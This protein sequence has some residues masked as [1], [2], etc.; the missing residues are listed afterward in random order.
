VPANIGESRQAL[1]FTGDSA[2][3]IASGVAIELPEESELHFHA[4]AGAPTVV[5]AVIPLA[6]VVNVHRIV[7]VR[8]RVGDSPA[9]FAENR[10]CTRVV[11][12]G[13]G[14]LDVAKVGQRRTDLMTRAVSVLVYR[15]RVRG[16]SLTS[17]PRIQTSDFV[18]GIGA[19]A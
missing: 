11:R 3:R 6:R 16:A 1:R 13:R 4:A 14:V 5:R 10:R 15:R 7:P 8:L 2:L 12:R 9:D 18:A 17:V 19:P